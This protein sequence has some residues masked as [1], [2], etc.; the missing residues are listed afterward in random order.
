MRYYTDKE[1]GR[2]LVSVTSVLPDLIWAKDEH[3]DRGTR[4]HKAVE[5]IERP[6]G[7]DRSSLLHTDVPYVEAYDK[8]KAE[9][10]WQPEHVEVVLGSERYG[11]AGK[12][13][14]VGTKQ[15]A[16]AVVDIK[17][18]DQTKPDPYW[19]VQLAGY[20]IALREVNELRPSAVVRRYVYQLRSDG[21]YRIYPME[22]PA[23]RTIFLAHLNIYKWKQKHNLKR[24]TR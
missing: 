19:G 11:F 15:R 1:T 22:D 3:K 24:E 13:D 8:L 17:S 10:G 9:T 21:T 12:V 5:L 16:V 20:E 14:Q 7:L 4:V 6:A 2:K 18:G 23:D